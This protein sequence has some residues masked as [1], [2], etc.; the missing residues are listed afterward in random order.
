MA[1]KQKTKFPNASA[2]WQKKRQAT[3]ACV[4][5]IIPSLILF[6]PWEKRLK[7]QAAAAARRALLCI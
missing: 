7:V 2:F 4:D 6:W 5:M 3:Y 1:Q